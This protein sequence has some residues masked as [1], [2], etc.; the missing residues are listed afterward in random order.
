MIFLVS[1]DLHLDTSVPFLLLIVVILR[2]CLTIIL[3]KSNTMYSIVF[4][5]W[6]IGYL[7]MDVLVYLPKYVV[8]LYVYL[9]I[10]QP[11]NAL[12]GKF[13]TK[14]IMGDFL[15]NIYLPLLSNNLHL[16][17]NNLPNST[18]NLK[19]LVFDVHSMVNVKCMSVTPKTMQ[20]GTMS[21][22]ILSSDCLLM[23]N[24]L[25]LCLLYCF[26]LPCTRFVKV[27]IH[28]QQLVKSIPKNTLIVLISGFPIGCVPT[29]LF[30]Q[31]DLPPVF[32]SCLCVS[33]HQFVILLTIFLWK[34]CTMPLMC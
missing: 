29:V 5:T 17:N 31:L 27:K 13:G 30:L 11:L 19:M 9:T 32:L 7:A 34:S 4:N 33:P 23:P 6:P 21:H 8:L 26:L 14:F 18:T 2:S 3:P 16:S 10:W 12:V 20:N 24:L 22:A 15:L 25:N 1:I 28:G